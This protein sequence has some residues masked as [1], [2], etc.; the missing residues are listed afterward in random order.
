MAYT[1][2]DI[3]TLSD[4]ITLLDAEFSEYNGSVWYRGQSNASWKLLPSYLREGKGSSESTLLAAF[5]QNAVML[6][7]KQL[8]NSFDWMFLMQHYGIPTR[9]LD[10]SESP[11]VALYFALDYTDVD[12]DA[13]VW[14]LKPTE[15]NSHAGIH[16]KEEEFFIPSF[17][18][19][20]VSSYSIEKLKND[21]P[22][23]ILKPIAT[24]ATRNNVRIQA[25]LGVF[26]IHHKEE[27]PIEEIGDGNHVIKITIKKEGKEKI[28]NQL[29]LLGINKFQLFPEL[30]SIKDMMIKRKII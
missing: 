25:Q 24:I 22:N 3:D 14:S 29:S 9:L 28:L 4:F 11:L 30:D 1:T 5:K 20:V 2:H 21:P 7:D 16:S 15:L 8:S 23:I 19:N 13:V 6:M 18:D 27:V 12:E 17:D 10:W 26:T